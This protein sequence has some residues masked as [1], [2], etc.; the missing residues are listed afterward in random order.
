[1]RERV[2]KTKKNR[3]GEGSECWRSAICRDEN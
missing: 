1:M 2:G 3:K